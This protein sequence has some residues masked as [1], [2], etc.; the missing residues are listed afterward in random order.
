MLNNEQHL[1]NYSMTLSNC[2]I[3][4][5]VTSSYSVTILNRVTQKNPP[6]VACTQVAIQICPKAEPTGN[7]LGLPMK[8]GYVL[9]GNLMS[10]MK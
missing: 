5:S 2:Y 7:L 4:G 8:N 9:F 10:K 1:A 6:K 3:T